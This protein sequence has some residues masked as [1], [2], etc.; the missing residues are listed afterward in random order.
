MR[1]SRFRLIR[2]FVVLTV[3][4]LLFCSLLVTSTSKDA[5]VATN[6]QH[7]SV[8]SASFDNS[9][10]EAE[11]ARLLKLGDSEDFEPAIASLLN[12]GWQH[13]QDQFYAANRKASA[14][15]GNRP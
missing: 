12:P 13:R 4:S 8:R 15:G 7:S 2:I 10:A 6:A 9:G 3:V 11:I 5:T 1:Y 14:Q